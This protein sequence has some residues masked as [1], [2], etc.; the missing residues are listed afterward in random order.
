AIRFVA[1]TL[2]K[3]FSQILHRHC[4]QQLRMD[5]RHTVRAMGAGNSKVGHAN[6]ALGTLL[7]QT[8]ALNPSLVSGKSASDLINQTTID[9]VDDL[10]VTRQ[11]SFKPDHGP[12]LKSFGQ[13]RVISVRQSP[14][15]NVPSLIPSE[16]PLIEQNPH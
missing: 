5:S 7:D 2:G 4:A 8:D 15:S 10:Q 9:F 14:V 16:T 13:E 11:H 1:E 12:F 6:F 3:H